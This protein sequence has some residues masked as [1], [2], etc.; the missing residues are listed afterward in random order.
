MD[1]DA[2]GRR[3]LEA[4]VDDTERAGRAPWRAL[5]NFTTGLHI[6]PLILALILS[7]ASGIV[8]PALTVFL[9][10]I[11][12]EFTSFGA[13]QISGHD[14]INRVKTYVVVLCGL[15][16]ASGILN[17]AYYGVWLIFG[18]LQAKS[19]REKLF[20]GMLDKDME[21]YDMRKLGIE[22]MVS[23][24]QTLVNPGTL[25]HAHADTS[26]AKS[27]ICSQQ[28]HNLLAS[29]FNILSPLSQPLAWHYT[30][31]GA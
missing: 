16:G 2:C 25:V 15:G 27:E 23:R 12:N 17:G 9:G 24:M 13:S 21:W 5:F 26:P 28:H 6:L 29:P 18:E 3:D 19:A 11:F 8:I 10:K 4:G 20:V 1:D 7:I 31:H 22:P 14:L 30:I